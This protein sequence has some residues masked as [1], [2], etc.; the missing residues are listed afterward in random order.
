MTFEDVSK[1]F[2]TNEIGQNILKKDE[3]DIDVRS[4]N[5]GTNKEMMS[6]KRE[7]SLGKTEETPKRPSIPQAH[8]EALPL[9][10]SPQAFQMTGRGTESPMSQCSTLKRPY[11]SSETYSDGARYEGWILNGKRHGQGK[12]YFR[13]GG[14]YEGDWANG[15]MEGW[16]KLFYV[17]G[18]TAYEGEWENDKFHGYGVLYNDK[19]DPTSKIDPENLSTVGQGWVKYEGEFQRDCKNG[20]GI[21]HFT[22][23][24]RYEGK[25]KDDKFDGEGKF[26]KQEGENLYGVW[27]SNRLS[28]RVAM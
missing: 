11:Q 3:P 28:H 27:K 6:Q 4:I 16:G 17:N 2:D 13:S 18:T 23:G 5:F 8:T 26:V 12:Y 21:C 22:D 25:F 1:V 15:K 7:Y 9:L 24:S 19:Q 20:F 10:P 14:Y